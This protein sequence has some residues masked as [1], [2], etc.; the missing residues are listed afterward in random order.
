MLGGFLKTKRRGE[1]MRDR[2][3][4]KKEGREEKGR[5]GASKQPPIMARL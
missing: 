1:E 3:E 2:K 5:S 4:K